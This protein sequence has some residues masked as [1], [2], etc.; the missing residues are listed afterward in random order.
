MSENLWNDRYR[1]RETPWDTGR[2]SREL[3]RVVAEQKI[4]PCRALEIGCGTGSNAVWLA[5]QGFDVTAFD[6]APLAIEQAEKRARDA[7]VTCRFLAADVL[8]PPDLGPAFDFLFD[9]GCYHAVR[10]NDAAGYLATLKKVIAPGGTAL[11]LTGNAREPH[12]PGPPVVSEEDIRRELGALLDVL[13]L[14]EFRFDAVP[15]VNESFLGWSILL[16]RK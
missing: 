14:R 6:L 16:R 1:T 7:G 11:I 12:E 13:A 10:R 9:R 2:P 3:Q 4:A 15:G 8:S 5:Q